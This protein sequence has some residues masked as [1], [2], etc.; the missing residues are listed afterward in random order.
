MYLHTVPDV[1]RAIG[2]RLRQYPFQSWSRSSATSRT[3]SNGDK[4]SACSPRRRKLV[5]EQRYLRPVQNVD[6]KLCNVSER[7]GSVPELNLKVA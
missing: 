5:R 1:C 7:P 2:I 4:P 3:Q 6:L